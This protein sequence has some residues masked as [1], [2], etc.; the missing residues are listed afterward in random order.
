M[1]YRIKRPDFGDDSTADAL[2]NLA[3][4][5][6]RRQ[7]RK[8]QEEIEALREAREA[9]QEARAVRAQERAE[10]TH[11]VSMMEAEE[12]LAERRRTEQEEI[13]GAGAMDVAMDERA[14]LERARLDGEIDDSE[15]SRQQG[16]VDEKVESWLRE[17]GVQDERVIATLRG[18]VIQGEA[19]ERDRVRSERRAQ[20]GE[21]RAEERYQREVSQRGIE[22]ERAQVALENARLAGEQKRLTLQQDRDAERQAKL[23]AANAQRIAADELV[24]AG[25]TNQFQRSYEAELLTLAQS[26]DLSHD[27]RIE[28]IEKLVDQTLEEAEDVVEPVALTK[29]ENELRGKISGQVQEWISEAEKQ[30]TLQQQRTVVDVERS[31]G[32]TVRSRAD[33]LRGAEPARQKATLDEFAREQEDW[34][35]GQIPWDGDD[36]VAARKQVLHSLVRDLYEDGVGE[37]A[38]ALWAK[39]EGGDDLLLNHEAFADLTAE[40]VEEAFDRERARLA[41]ADEADRVRAGHALEDEA[42]VQAGLVRTAMVLA[43]HGIDHQDVIRQMKQD[44][45][46]PQSIIE[47][48]EMRVSLMETRANALDADPNANRTVADAI[49]DLERADSGEA[50]DQLEQ[51]A[52]AAMF[53]GTISPS[54]YR[55]VVEHVQAAA[56]R[57]AEPET[58]SGIQVA[59]LRRLVEENVEDVYIDRDQNGHY[60]AHMR[61]SMYGAA[62]GPVENA[63]VIQFVRA[64]KVQLMADGQYT[65]GSMED[66]A[67]H[68]LIRSMI[69]DRLHRDP[70]TDELS[71]AAREAQPAVDDD[72]SRW[73][74]ASERLIQDVK[75][76]GIEAGFTARTLATKYVMFPRQQQVLRFYEDDDPRAGQIDLAETA[77]AV[78]RLADEGGFYDTDE[79]RRLRASVIN[80]NR[81]F[82]L[83]STGSPKPDPMKPAPLP[84]TE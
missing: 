15:Y 25:L 69:D 9:R 46:S 29:L 13:W 79:Y 33:A 41:K 28:R 49:L 37:E 8:K 20:A 76:Q 14:R 35:G 12:R 30:A 50:V 24:S 61:G 72:Y 4:A 31:R 43:D 57:L 74:T 19:D 44:G 39:G 6:E 65:P 62:L 21:V 36:E 16:E 3:D 54:Q 48:E 52:R 71:A 32:R 5:L 59:E 70:A 45:A 64:M 80:V 17:Q 82:D 60:V 58:S 77:V 27:E 67:A 83:L 1:P 7:R 22:D 78:R 26:P 55:E 75:A 18:R 2:F 38:Y 63:E 42:R 47:F 40:E 10:E 23:K 53:S 11:A 73:L 56:A 66:Q 81:L 68:M 84:G 34:R 51:D